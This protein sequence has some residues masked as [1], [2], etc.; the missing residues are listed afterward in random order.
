MLN[1]N[2]MSRRAFVGTTV[3]VAA[4]AAL[5]LQ[6]LRAAV[7]LYGD[8]VHDD[9]D[10]LQALF[11]GHPVRPM[12]AGM[13]ARNENGTVRLLNGSFQMREP[14]RTNASTNLY[15]GHCSFRLK[16]GPASPYPWLTCVN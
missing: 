1:T 12:Q 5:P 14:I 3:A 9:T 4:A 11:D 8:G 7:P 6:S 16:D 10:A 15:S 2:K 13:V